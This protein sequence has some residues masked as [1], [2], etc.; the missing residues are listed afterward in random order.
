MSSSPVSVACYKFEDFSEVVNCEEYCLNIADG[1]G[2]MW[3]LYFTVNP[4]EEQ[5]DGSTRGD[6]SVRGYIYLCDQPN[7]VDRI[8]AK[9]S[10]FVRNQSGDVVHKHNIPTTT[11]HHDAEIDYL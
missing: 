2:T 3:Q 4:L 11:Y 6:D 8:T 9:V 5:D 10:L 7:D 1:R